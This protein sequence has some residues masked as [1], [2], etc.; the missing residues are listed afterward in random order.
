MSKVGNH[1][2]HQIHETL[3][4][5]VGSTAKYYR[6]AMSNE[7]VK[8]LNIPPQFHTESELI[9]LATK[10]NGKRSRNHRTGNIRFTDSRDLCTQEDEAVSS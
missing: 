5:A 8:I 4:E 9:R 3:T 2:T 7:I 1:E 10:H 6:L